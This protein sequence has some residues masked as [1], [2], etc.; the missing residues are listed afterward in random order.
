MKIKIC[1]ISLIILLLL[2]NKCL[3]L[4]NFINADEVELDV[5]Q[6]VNLA[7]LGTASEPA[8]SDVNGGRLYFNSDEDVFKVSLSGDAYEEL[9]TGGGD[10]S[11]GGDTE[12]ANRTLGNKDAFSLG[13]LTSNATR[14]SID[15]I[16]NVG[17][18]TESPGALLDI[19]GAAVFNDDGDDADFRIEGDSEPDLFFVDASVDFVGLGTNT[20]SALLHGDEGAFV[21]TGTTGTTPVSGTGTRM[22]WVPAKAAFRAGQVVS[23]Q[24]DDANVGTGSMVLGRF[25]EATALN[26]VAIGP[27]NTS[28]N[29]AS[30]AIGSSATASALSATALGKDVTASGTSSVAIGEFVTAGS[31]SNAIA[32]GRGADASNNLINNVTNTFMVAMNS[33]VP[34]LTVGPSSGVGTTGNVGIGISVPTTKLDIDGAV[35]VRASSAPSEFANQGVL[36][37]DTTDN[38]FKVSENSDGFKKLVRVNNDSNATFPTCDS[39]LAGTIRVD[40][41]ANTG[42]AYVCDNSRSP[43]KWLALDDT[44]IWGDESGTCP[45]GANPD[46]NP[47][48]NV[49]WGNGLGPDGGTDLGFFI[50]NPITIT[51]YGFSADNNPCADPGGLDI[52]VWGTGSNSNDS[53]YID[54]TVGNPPE[55]A[56][57]TTA[58]TTDT[59]NANNLNIDLDGE[60]YIIWGI[61][62]NCDTEGVDD[63]NVI[64]YFRWRHD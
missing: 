37:F 15:S 19:R 50:A 41:A 33:N 64:L 62:N 59:S 13:F 36:Y 47:N 10:F 45:A 31:A 57:V 35:A 40:T 29:T 18:G 4:D 22:M 8:V 51:G 3:A 7:G 34:T 54:P 52:E 26:S 38:D 56:V 20:P 30:V 46:S 11:N 16:G 6:F 61:R 5:E 49:D 14:L 55:S 48:C 12:S 43:S 60:Q 63:F 24:W 25:S 1:Q 23:T 21:F 17:I 44:L 58:I 32:I 9:A 42:T 2:S 53:T 39:S 27:N 28:S